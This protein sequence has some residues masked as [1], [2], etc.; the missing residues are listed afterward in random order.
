MANELREG[1]SPKLEMS[2]FF[3]NKRG[4]TGELVAGEAFAPIVG[5]QYVARVSF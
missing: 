1:L 3:R 4:K 5:F 2:E